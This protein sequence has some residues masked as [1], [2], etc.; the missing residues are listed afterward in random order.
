MLALVTGGQGFIG[1]HLCERLL[2][3]G[4][5]VRVLARSGS[6][7][8]NLEGLPVETVRGDLAEAIWRR[9]WRARSGCSTWRA[10]SR[11]SGKPT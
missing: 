9:P 11:G 5:R 10:R 8:A 7:L 3:A 4:H 2:A 1:S 6:S